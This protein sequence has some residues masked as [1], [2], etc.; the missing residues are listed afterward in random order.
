MFCPFSERVNVGN[1]WRPSTSFKTSFHLFAFPWTW[2][3]SSAWFYLIGLWRCFVRSR[4]LFPPKLTLPS[5][6][7]APSAQMCSTEPS[8]INKVKNNKRQPGPWSVVSV[9]LYVRDGVVVD[10]S[11]RVHAP[12]HFR[13]AIMSICTCR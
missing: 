9:M 5:F 7:Q 11:V 8:D 1:A 13:C 2:W 3:R 12:L 10:G 6:L 4:S